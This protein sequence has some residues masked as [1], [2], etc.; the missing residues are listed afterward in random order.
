VQRGYGGVYYA[1]APLLHLLRG[2]SMQFIGCGRLEL[3]D[4]PKQEGMLSKKVFTGVL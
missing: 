2:L 4:L 3:D 1:F